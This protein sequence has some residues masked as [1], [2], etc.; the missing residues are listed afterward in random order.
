MPYWRKS[1]RTTNTFHEWNI[2]EKV[3]AVITDNAKN[4]VNSIPLISS[5]N[6]T[7]IFSIK[8]AAYTL[9]LAVNHA[10]KNE[11]ISCIIK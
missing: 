8:C 11:S 1:C 7:Q 5:I 3:L 10:L 9:K 6:E 4:I 2:S